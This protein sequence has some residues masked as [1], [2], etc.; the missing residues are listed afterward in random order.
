MLTESQK[1]AIRAQAMLDNGVDAREVARECGY[2]NVNGMMGAIALSVRR[3]PANDIQS[4]MEAV[5]HKQDTSTPDVRSGE[6]T[7]PG[8]YKLDNGAIV[9]VGTRVSQNALQFDRKTYI[10][11][12]RIRQNERTEE[13]KVETK[14]V[15]CKYRLAEAGQYEARI[16]VYG[17]DKWLVIDEEIIGGRAELK[18]VLKD[19]ANGINCILD[20]LS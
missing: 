2:K 11:K 4:E 9:A 18:R 12:V 8:F 5:M 7:E 10:E 19:I 16:H 17:I 20:G 1:R 13:A 15:V 14:R 6:Y 3:L